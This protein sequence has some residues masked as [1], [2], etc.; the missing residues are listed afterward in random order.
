MYGDKSIQNISEINALEG[1]V[2][3]E[4]GMKHFIGWSS[5]VLGHTSSSH[6]GRP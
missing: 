3:G 6:L 5:T 1:Q 2:C 4:S